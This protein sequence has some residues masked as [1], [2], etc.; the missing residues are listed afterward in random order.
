MNQGFTSLN[1]APTLVGLAKR[2]G[3]L[4]CEI[5]FPNTPED[6]EDRHQEAQAPCEGVEEKDSKADHP[7]NR[8]DH[9]EL[10]DHPGVLE[11]GRSPINPLA[12]RTPC[13]A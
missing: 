1:T 2:M 12:R 8:S 4:Y 10:P 6:Q 5:F 3:F 11:M 9:P 7:D 13:L